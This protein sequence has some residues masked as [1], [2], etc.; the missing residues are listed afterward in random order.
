MQGK[1][2]MKLPESGSK[3]DY[4]FESAGCQY[5]NIRLASSVKK[6]WTEFLELSIHRQTGVNLI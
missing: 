2:L 4:T 3:S 1:L 5:G 6:C